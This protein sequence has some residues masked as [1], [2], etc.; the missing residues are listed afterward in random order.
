MDVKPA[1]STQHVTGVIGPV[2]VVD[3]V[4]LRKR[5]QPSLSVSHLRVQ[6]VAC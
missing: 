4:R 5:K 6:N 3:R 2:Q 1:L